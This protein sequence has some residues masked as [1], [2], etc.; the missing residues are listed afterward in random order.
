MRR[1]CGNLVTFW[2]IPGLELCN[3]Y[4]RTF[5]VAP[6]EKVVNRGYSILHGFADYSHP[7]EDE[8]SANDFLHMPS[9]FPKETLEQ[10][11]PFIQGT[12][13]KTFLLSIATEKK[14]WSPIVHKGERC[15]DRKDREEGRARYTSTSNFLVRYLAEK[16]NV[17]T[18]RCRAT[19]NLWSG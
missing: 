7:L 8:A 4:A 10:Q 16:D 13:Q 18:V 3:G 15:F 12:L 5:L 2:M 17:C 14:M 11:Q 19:L 9:S 1:H 6:K